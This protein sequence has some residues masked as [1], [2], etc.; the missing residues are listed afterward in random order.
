MEE[1]EK[2]AC[3]VWRKVGE[4][5]EYLADSLFLQLDAA[6]HVVAVLLVAV[7]GVDEDAV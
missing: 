3:G 5:D 2:E 4:D 1:E 7:E 6:V